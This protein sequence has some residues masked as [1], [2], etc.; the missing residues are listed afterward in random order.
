MVKQKPKYIK[1]DLWREYE[2]EKQRTQRQAQAAP[3]MCL[4]DERVQ[5]HG[6]DTTHLWS[7]RGGGHGLGGRHPGNGH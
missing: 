2:A 4:E 7:K 6:I 5:P 3:V 1:F